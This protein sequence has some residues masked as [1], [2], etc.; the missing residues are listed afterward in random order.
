LTLGAA[1]GVGALLVHSLFDFNLRL[2]ANALAFVL[3]IA[4]AAAPHGTNASLGGRR[5]AVI[6]GALFAVAA[7]AAAWRAHGAMLLARSL[8][9]PPSRRIAALDVVAGQH[10]YLA[11]AFRERALA[12]RRLAAGRPGARLQRAV[13][14]LE[15]ALEIRPLWA[16]ARA[17]LAWT[18][19]AA[20]DHGAAARDFAQAV[21]LDPTHRGI[22][23]AHAE[24][25]A[26][27]QESRP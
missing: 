10:P 2:P 8:D 25:L 11:V 19:F 15:R 9:A 6:A 22:S 14:D 13:R 16:E 1:A 4:L 26:R 3:L 24:F 21:R 7:A 27:S 12:W 5:T 20:G 17:D 18:L 23:L